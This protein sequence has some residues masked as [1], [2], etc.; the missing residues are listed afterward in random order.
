MINLLILIKIMNTTTDSLI[1]YLQGGI[2][3]GAGDQSFNYQI[4]EDMNDPMEM[5]GNFMNIINY[6]P[7]TSIITLYR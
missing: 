5:R 2:G 4:E 1:K 6:V 7:L 3:G